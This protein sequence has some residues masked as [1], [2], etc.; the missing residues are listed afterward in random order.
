[1]FRLSAAF[2]EAA[3]VHQAPVF[4]KADSDDVSNRQLPSSVEAVRVDKFFDKDNHVVVMVEF[5]ALGKGLCFVGG[6]L[7]QLPPDRA[8]ATYPGVKAYFGL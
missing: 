5:R 1:M 2:S 7:F 8:E 6:S 4:D 3:P